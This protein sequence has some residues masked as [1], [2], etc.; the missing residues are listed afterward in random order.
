MLQLRKDGNG[1]DG[2]DAGP[3]VAIEQAT[4][5]LQGDRFERWRT[6]TGQRRDTNLAERLLLT[7]LACD[8]TVVAYALLGAFWLRF[9]PV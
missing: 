9:R 3:A 5:L 7:A 1:M 6:S 2:G 4:G 8:T